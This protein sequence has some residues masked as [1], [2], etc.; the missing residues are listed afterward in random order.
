MLLRGEAQRRRARWLWLCLPMQ[1]SCSVV[2]LLFPFAF[3][4]LFPVPVAIAQRI[5]EPPAW[6]QNP[7]NRITEQQSERGVTRSKSTSPAAQ[8]LKTKPSKYDVD[9]IGQRNIGR[10]SNLYSL[11]RERRLGSALARD[12]EAHTKLVADPVIAEYMNGLGQSIVR[13]SDAQMPFTIKVIDSDEVN[14]FVLPGGYLYVN[15]GLIMTSEN[16]AEL[17]SILAH[18]IAHVAARHAARSQRHQRRWKLAAFCSGPAGFAVQVA[19][20]LTFM[21][22][23]R[24]AEREADLLGLEYQYATG[25]DPQAF[26][27]FFEKL[28]AKDGERHDWIAKV[29]ATHPMTEERIRRAEEEIATLLPPK[30][31]YITDTSEFEEVKSRLASFTAVGASPMIH[32]QYSAEVGCWTRR[33]SDRVLVRAGYRPAQHLLTG[34]RKELLVVE[35][36]REAF[37]R[38]R[39]TSCPD[40]ASDSG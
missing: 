35:S 33:C 31:E 28:Q 16:E 21:K 24:D 37:R 32:Y 30:A 5:G 23:N 3:L 1:P 14:A 40:E 19:G 4:F 26:V 34:L 39:V 13:H 20:F 11:E 18:E 7:S 38:V 25:Y 9:R 2:Y 27:Q 17:A 6:I 15:S 36:A 12:I 8:E 29:F 22:L 10:G